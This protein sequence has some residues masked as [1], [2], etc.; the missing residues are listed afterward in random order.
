NANVRC[1]ITGKKGIHPAGG[2]EV[3][4]V[5]LKREAQRMRIRRNPQLAI[6]R[7][8][9]GETREAIELITD[10]FQRRIIGAAGELYTDRM[11]FGGSRCQ[12]LDLHFESSIFYFEW[13]AGEV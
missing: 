6:G 3:R 9:R 11:R 1:G 7:N 12:I 10:V 5:V 4:G 8:R 13:I 2:E